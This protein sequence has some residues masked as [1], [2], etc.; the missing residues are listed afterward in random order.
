MDAIVIVVSFAL[1]ISIAETD[2]SGELGK[3]IL[4]VFLM[5]RM[6]R[7][8]NGKPIEFD[9]WGQKG[10]RIGS[11]RLAKLKLALF[12]YKFSPAQQPIMSDQGVVSNS[13]VQYRLTVKHYIKLSNTRSENRWKVMN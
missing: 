7:I 13:L 10:Q 6:I 9:Y 2:L 12:C 3:T 8:L 1:D 5:W 4:I 11:D